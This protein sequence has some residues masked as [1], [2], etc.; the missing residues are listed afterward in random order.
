MA[1]QN[2]KIQ[3]NE[4]ATDQEVV[5]NR[6]RDTLNELGFRFVMSGSDGDGRDLLFERDL[7]DTK[8]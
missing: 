6:L 2:L 3:F 8:N 5:E 7:T 4:M 1:A